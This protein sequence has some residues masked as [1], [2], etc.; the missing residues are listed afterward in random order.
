MVLAQRSTA[1]GSLTRRI[2]PERLARPCKVEMTT[3][4]IVA[5]NGLYVHSMYEYTSV[6]CQPE[7]SMVTEE[8]SKSEVT[9]YHPNANCETNI[10]N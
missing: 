3:S 8:M 4:P 2:K 10:I 1:T 9:P 5:K 7:V 6:R